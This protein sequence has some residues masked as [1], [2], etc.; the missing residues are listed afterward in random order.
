[1]KKLK[2]KFIEESHKYYDEDTGK[3][4][5][6]VTTLLHKYCNEFPEDEAATK[7]AA[8]R[9]LNKE[10]VIKQWREYNKQSTEYGSMVHL[11]L[12][13]YLKENKL[14][15]TLKE[16]KLIENFDKLNL[17]TSD[18][19]ELLSEYRVYHPEALICGTMDL[20]ILNKED[21]II[22][23]R[24]FKTNR[25]GID[26]VSEKNPMYYKYMKPPLEHYHDSNY[27]HYQLQM[28]IYG[29]FWE[30]RGYTVGD[31]QILWINPDTYQIVPIGI[32]YV[33]NDVEKLVSLRLKEVERTYL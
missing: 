23:I 20:G 22:K 9:N 16:K 6:S 28:S 4:L 21:K 17:V 24:D 25:R 3:E 26:F 27:Y 7:Y 11:T 10:D 30:L 33:K 8:K 29:Y 18:K 32:E 15:D 5:I 19:E 1:M 31:M 12:E 13:N 14:P 2:I